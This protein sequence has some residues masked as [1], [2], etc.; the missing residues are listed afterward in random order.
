MAGASKNTRR[1]RVVNANWTPGPD[2]TDG[3][4]GLLVVTEDDQRHEF[5]PSPAAV[6]AL[7]ALARAGTVLLFDPDGP[8]LVTANVVGEW[9]PEDWSA[10]DR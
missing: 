9:L 10:L 8:T 7:L 6:T 3:T 5:S 4:F 2:G 1:V